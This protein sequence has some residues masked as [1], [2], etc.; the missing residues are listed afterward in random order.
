MSSRSCA[1]HWAA[2]EQRK[3]SAKHSWNT[4]LSQRKGL[5]TLVDRYEVVI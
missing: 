1:P 5:L 4:P 2:E 3:A